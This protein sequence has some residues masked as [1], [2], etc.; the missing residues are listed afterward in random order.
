MSKRDEI[1]RTPRFKPHP[2][3][4]H[5]RETFGDR[6]GADG[7]AHSTAIYFPLKKA[8]HPAGIA[9]TGG[10]VALLFR[11]GARIVDA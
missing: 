6:E 1:I 5:C 4:G 10:A 2:E 8:K 3:G 9:S 7:R 11:R